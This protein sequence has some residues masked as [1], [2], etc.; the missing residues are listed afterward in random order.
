MNGD[1]L[2]NFMSMFSA[3]AL[4]LGVF[5]VALYLA[6]YVRGR[7]QRGRW[8]KVLAATDMGAKRTIALVEVMEEVLVLG[9]APQHISLLSKVEKPELVRR[10]KMVEPP[11]PTTLFLQILERMFAKGRDDS[12]TAPPDK[13]KDQAHA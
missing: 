3:L 7:G 12:R 1:L 13:G 9:I 2:S 6:T 11:K 5:L 10:L 8:I 4:V